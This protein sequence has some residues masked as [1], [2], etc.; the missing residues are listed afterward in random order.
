MRKVILPALLLFIPTALGGE[1]LVGVCGECGHVTDHYFYGGG[2][3]PGHLHLYYQDLESGLLYEVYF[4]LVVKTAEEIG[5]TI[6]NSHRE[7]GEFT[8]AHYDEVAAAHNGFTP[9]VR[10]DELSG[11]E[12]LPLWVEL[13][14]G[15][16]GEL[17]SLVLVEE[18][19]GGGFTCPECGAPELRLEF[20]GNWD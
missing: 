5:V 12:G 16:S 10:L 3:L 14:E 8:E 18:L 2:M 15:F 7:I 17:H 9:P 1:I 13:E 19:L 6:N 4:N 20:V 11:E